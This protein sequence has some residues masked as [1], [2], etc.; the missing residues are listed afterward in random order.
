MA[1]KVEEPNIEAELTVEE[2]QKIIKDLKAKNSVLETEKIELTKQSKI[3]KEI[4]KIVEVEKIIEKVIEIPVE[5]IVEVS[6]PTE[7]NYLYEI[8]DMV[9]CPEAYQRLKFEI[10]GK[11][12]FGAGQPL[13]RLLDHKNLIEMD[14]VPEDS[15]HLF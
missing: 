8:G 6:V 9:Y 2:L 15:I 11:Q 5:R 14:M 10:R 7:I 13:Y 12:G 3:I 4:E 1:K